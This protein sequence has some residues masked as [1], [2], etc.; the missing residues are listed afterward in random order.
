MLRIGEQTVEV[1]CP[2]CSIRH[3]YRLTTRQ[4]FIDDNMFSLMNV[5]KPGERA[6]RARLYCVRSGDEFTA[7][8]RLYETLHRRTREIHV[9]DRRPQ[10]VGDLLA[11]SAAD[12]TPDPNTKPRN[13]TPL[14]LGRRPRSA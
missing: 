8:V 6:F 10:A 11:W 14:R 2:I 12:G 9:R 3:N 7:D 4:D 13:R 5:R 1:L